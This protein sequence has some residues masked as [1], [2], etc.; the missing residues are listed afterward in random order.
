MKQAY[1]LSVVCIL[2]MALSCMAQ[3]APHGRASVDDPVPQVGPPVRFSV[4]E[5]GGVWG[6]V[7]AVLGIL[8][9][10]LGVVSVVQSTNKQRISLPFT[11]ILLGCLGALS[12]LLGL[13]GSY[14]AMWRGMHAITGGDFDSVNN[15]P[16]F[17]VEQ[18]S[19]LRA[20]VLSALAYLFWFTGSLVVFR[21][22]HKET[23]T[24][25]PE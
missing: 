3:K 24:T 16:R 11:T 6:I 4:F 25:R 20:G 17:L 23:R 19:C 9:I 18:V 14:Q 8:S 5:V 22:T 7:A 15:L 21:I 2:A 13:V 12:L 1:W 10:P